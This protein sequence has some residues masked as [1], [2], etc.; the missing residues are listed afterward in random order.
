MII[1]IQENAKEYLEKTGTKKLLI[2]MTPDMTNSGC[3]CGK[4]KKFYTPCIRAMKADE[5][6]REYKQ[7]SI[8]DVNIFLSPKVLDA[9]EDVVII[10]L[11]K[12]LFMK[13][14]ELEGI[15]FIVE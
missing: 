9:A 5:H 13:K 12:T 11:E 8:D 6:F 10:K 7:Y 1:K 14:L 2:D 15:R 3:G 4:T